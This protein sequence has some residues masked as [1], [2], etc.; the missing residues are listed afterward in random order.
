MQTALF[1]IVNG[2]G[3]KFPQIGTHLYLQKNGILLHDLFAR[4]YP[5][6]I[7]IMG[8]TFIFGM[9][10]FITAPIVNPFKN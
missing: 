9:V 1:N 2:N 3:D 8:W 4:S 10:K 7:Y 5:T 6:S